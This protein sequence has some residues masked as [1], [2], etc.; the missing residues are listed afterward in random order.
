[1]AKEEFFTMR[2]VILFILS[3]GIAFRSG[4][5]YYYKD[6]VTTT[7]TAK[8]LQQF[9]AQKIRSVK[10]LS[11]EGNGQ[12]VE[13]FA[14]EQ[15]FNNNYTQVKTNTKSS[16]SNQSELE[17]LYD[18]NGR[19]NRT[20]DTTDGFSSTTEYAYNS[21]NKLS[22]LTN[23]SVSAGQSLEKEQHLWYYNADGKPERMVKIKNNTDTTHISFVVDEQG[24][25]AEENS[26]R[27]GILLPSVYY[28]Y[29]NNDRL[30]DI[31]RYSRKAKRL[32]PDYIFEYNDQGDISSMLLIPEGS[33]DYQRWV[34]QYG[35]D[36][37]KI[38][39]TAFNKKRQVIG[40]IEYRYER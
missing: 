14:V 38:K 32:L 1:M 11:F 24:N 17:T 19:I 2:I 25:V 30:T 5:Q 6:L 31:V 39:E 21:D 18:N 29:D 35:E 10:V 13:D 34:Y 16:A 3:I 28:Y 26:R 40:R 15:A 9:K 27:N 36:G 4:A 37:L 22:S 20:T 8:Q 7:Q 23:I 12:P 33:D